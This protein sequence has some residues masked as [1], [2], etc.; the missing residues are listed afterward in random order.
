MR[1][2][3]Y[4]DIGGYGWRSTASRR[5]VAMY[6]QNR[7]SGRYRQRPVPRIVFRIYALFWLIPVVF[8]MAAPTTSGLLVAICIAIVVWI[9][10]TTASWQKPEGTAEVR[11][12][13]QP[14]EREHP[15]ACLKQPSPARYEGEVL[16]EKIVCYDDYEQPQAHYPG[17]KQRGH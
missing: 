11:S 8:F 15:P 4:I 10:T 2:Y 17:Q 7:R 5:G 9:F 14:L 6:Y 16:D 13:Y 1:R 12:S 3:R